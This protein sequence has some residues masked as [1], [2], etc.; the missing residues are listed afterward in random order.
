MQKKQDQCKTT[1]Y[2]RYASTVHTTYHKHI[3]AYEC[4]SV[5]LI[6]ET[7]GARLISIDLAI[8]PETVHK[9]IYSRSEVC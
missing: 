7:M 1:D 5:F 2:Y 3:L 9:L 4:Q 6:G 8:P